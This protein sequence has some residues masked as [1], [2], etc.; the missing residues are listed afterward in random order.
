METITGKAG[1]TSTSSLRKLDQAL[2]PTHNLLQYQDGQNIGEE[3]CSF[4]VY[5]A[6]PLVAKVEH[7]KPYVKS[8]FMR[9]YLVHCSSK[10]ETLGRDCTD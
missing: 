4:W 5:L 2:S 1:K 6:L 7:I 9:P 3:V 8:V 10:D